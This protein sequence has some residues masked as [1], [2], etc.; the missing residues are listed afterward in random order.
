[1]TYYTIQK[2]ILDLIYYACNQVETKINHVLKLF[3]SP[4]IISLGKKCVPVSLN[5][6]NSIFYDLL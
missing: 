4:K 5:Q 6:I 1:M 3:C 2:K